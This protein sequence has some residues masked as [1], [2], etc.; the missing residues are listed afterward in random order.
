MMITVSI[1]LLVASIVCFIFRFGMGA[2]VGAES[3]R[4]PTAR[5]RYGSVIEWSSIVAVSMSIIGI[6][7]YII[8]TK[9]A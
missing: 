1:T 3:R 6:V 8:A 4:D 7:L 2:Y 9:S 5:D